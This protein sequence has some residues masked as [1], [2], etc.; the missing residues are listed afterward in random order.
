MLQQLL[1]RTICTAAATHVAERCEGGVGGGARTAAVPLRQKALWPELVGRR[2]VLWAV[3]E[4]VH[5][6]LQPSR[7]LAVIN[8]DKDEVFAGTNG[9]HI[10]VT[11]L[12]NTQAAGSAAGSRKQA[13]AH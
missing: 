2:P 3:L 11:S 5:R 8:A 9:H 1:A 10:A 4:A 13:D 7:Y 6:R 12:C